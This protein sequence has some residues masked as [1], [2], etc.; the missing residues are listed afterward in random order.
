MYPRILQ[1]A[2]LIALAVAVCASYLTTAPLEA[3]TPHNDY[4][5]YARVQFVQ[6]CAARAG[7]SQADLYKCSCVI[8][9]IAEHLTFDQYVE[10]ST[11]AHY[12]T[13]PGEGGGEF[14][15]PDHAKEQARLYRTLETQAYRVCGLKPPALSR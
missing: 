15:D 2:R 7:G 10:A 5:T 1:R 14:R 6:D 8:D 4:P 3:D 9:N 13:L 12:A 11:F